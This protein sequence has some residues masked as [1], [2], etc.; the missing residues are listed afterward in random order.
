M[1]GTVFPGHTDL[2][3]G[4]QD[5]GLWYTGDGGAGWT[6]QGPDVYAT[7]ADHDGNPDASLLWLSCFGC[8]VNRSNPGATGGAAFTLPP[9]SAVANNFHATQF[10]PGSYAFI[11]PDGPTSGSPAPPPPTW[12]VWITTNSGGTWTQ[13]GPTIPATTP[14]FDIKASGP[15]ASPTFYLRLK[16]AGNPQLYRLVGPLN[17]SASLTELTNG[18][19]RAGTFAVTPANPD[20]LY[21]SDYQAGQVVRSTNGGASFTPDTA[22]TSLVTNGGA[23][24]YTS[25]LG[26]MVSAID[27]DGHSSQA[28]VGTQ[29]NGLFASVDGGANW[30]TVRGSAGLTRVTNFF[31]DQQNHAIFG[32]SAGR[33]MWRITLPQADLGI[34]VTA[35]SPTIAGQELLYTVTVTNHGP[36]PASKI[37]AT[38]NLPGAVSF[39]ASTG[40]CVE[41]PAASGHV[42]C[43]VA[44]LPSGG[45]ATFTI[46]VLVHSDVDVVGGGPTSVDNTVSV[47]THETV[48]TNPANDSATATVIVNERANLAVNKICDGSVQA[49][50]SGTCTIYVDNNGPSDARAASVTDRATSNGTF[51]IASATPSQGACGPVAGGQ[52]TCTLGT[53]A[54]KT[55]SDTGRATIVVYYSASDGQTISDVAAAS[56]PTPDPDTSDNTAVASLTYT[57]VAD[58]A[59]T[60]FSGSPAP[61][62]AGTHLTYT[63]SV[64]N[65][66]PSTATNVVF[67]QAIPAGVQVLSV[68]STPAGTPC[69]AG[70][71]GDPLQPATCGFDVMTAGSTR[72]ITAIV[73]VLPQTQGTLHSD[74][75]VGSATFDPNN[76]NNNA[77]TDNAL[78]AS[79][80]IALTLTASPN[81][82]TA[83]RTLT[84]TATISNAGP[85]TARTVTLIEPLPAGTTLAGTSISNGGS[86]VCSLVLP[87]QVQCQLN[88][89]EPAQTVTVY[90]TVNVAGG[91]TGPLA[92]TAQAGTSSSD[93]A[94]ANN[95]A[96]VSTNVQTSANLAITYSGP[97]I[98]KP[99][100]TVPY[101]I[102]LTNNGP[103]DAQSVVIT[104]N[105]P[106]PT[107]GHFVSDNSGGLCTVNAAQV[108]TCNLGTVKAGAGKQIQVNYFVQGNNKVINSLVTVASPTPDPVSANNSAN[109]SMKSK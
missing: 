30:L 27:L 100:T 34:A 103:S 92:M 49:G 78:T 57:S 80:D 94:S 52:F 26:D 48:D 88:D 79:A 67:R 75:T 102:A 89:L 10:G 73:K 71:P 90:T 16:T 41:S 6:E 62:V 59:I 105:L 87:T 11:T 63:A 5:N 15:A 69:T 29:T 54:A 51:T 4:T 84:Y 96:T 93:P 85:S 25:S 38:D 98:Y 53:L 3:F 76:S 83:G 55:L 56:S 9:G 72:T 39:V 32:A 68:D 64:V 108:L 45:S 18:V 23:S 43:P 7:Y 66:G 81:P 44:D 60:S 46:K 47:A 95:S 50:Q 35:P 19:Q 2:Y 101:Q 61:V 8:S 36:D 91:A 24:K 86:G 42:T 22:L 13:M 37:V 74:A 33:G 107:I 58:L 106:A 97:T 40:G 70:V 65:N 1:A 14:P 104:D 12:K 31:F 109:W 17:G 99:S 77:H 20:I 82:V 21:V 28:I